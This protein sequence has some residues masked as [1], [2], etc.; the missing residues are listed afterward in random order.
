MQQDIQEQ[1]AT[2]ALRG[3]TANIV[4]QLFAIGRQSKTLTVWGV[5]RPFRYKAKGRNK[6]LKCSRC[7]RKRDTT[8]RYCRACR[9]KY[10]SLWR[11]A[12]RTA[13]GL[14]RGTGKPITRK[15]R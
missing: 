1:G 2:A 13:N 11:D 8:G 3:S 15:A 5:R 6:K 14:N 7:N 10:I 9:R 4:S 12:N